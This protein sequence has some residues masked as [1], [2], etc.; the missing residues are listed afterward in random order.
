PATDRAEPGIVPYEHGAVFLRPVIALRFVK[1]ALEGADFARVLVGG[2]YPSVFD[3][4]FLKQRL[5]LF[6]GTFL[7]ANLPALLLNFLLVL[8]KRLFRPRRRERR[9]RCTPI[10]PLHRRPIA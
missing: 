2:Q 3:L 4:L 7:S 1:R 6:F 9:A 10:L 8:L 5:H